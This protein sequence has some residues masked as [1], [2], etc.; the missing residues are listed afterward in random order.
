MIDHVRSRFSS[1]DLV[2]SM[3]STHLAFSNGEGGEKRSEES[4]RSTV[5]TSVV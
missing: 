2:K 3:P 5:W 1:G 4:E